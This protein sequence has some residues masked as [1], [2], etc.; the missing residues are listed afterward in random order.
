MSPIG[1]GQ[2]M[3]ERTI[4]WGYK[5]S[6]SA[7]NVLV[8]FDLAGFIIWMSDPV[9]AGRGNDQVLWWAT[10]R[11]L[12]IHGG[13]GGPPGSNQLKAREL[14]QTRCRAVSAGS[15]DEGFTDPAMLRHDVTRLQAAAEHG[16]L[17]LKAGWRMLDSGFIRRPIAGS[18]VAW[19]VGAAIHNRRL[20][21]YG[22]ER[23]RR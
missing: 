16:I 22:P 4:E 3:E 15:A 11:H 17:R 20:R 2:T 7:W 13:G 8:L 19:R 18:K 14:G 6:R 1:R 5:L 21:L 9:V 12:V 23:A 10:R